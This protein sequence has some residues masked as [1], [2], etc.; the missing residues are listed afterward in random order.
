MSGQEITFD[1]NGQPAKGYLAAPSLPEAPG[2]I[3]LHAWWGLNQFFKDLCD[4]LAAETQLT[5][6]LTI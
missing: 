4:R 2:V 6:C 5:M 1:V 3:V